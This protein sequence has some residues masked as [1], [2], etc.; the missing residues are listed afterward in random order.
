MIEHGHFDE[1]IAAVYDDYES[2][3]TRTEFAAEDI[4]AT[5]DF[6]A[7]LAGEGD[8]LE[9]GVGTGRIALPLVQRASTRTAL[10]F[11]E[12]WWTG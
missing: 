5:V 1:R 2:D 9:F 11:R 12:R 10:T 7:Q 6:L 3:P 8:A 4:E